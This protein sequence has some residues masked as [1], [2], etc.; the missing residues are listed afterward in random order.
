MNVMQI[1]VLSVFLGMLASCATPVGQFKESDMTWTKF[2]MEM[3]YQSVFRN[4]KEGFR[5]C[6]NNFFADGSLY[7]DVKEGHFDIYLT[8]AFGGKSPWVYGVVNI[9][10]VDENHSTFAVGVV[11]AYDNPMFGKEGGGRE[12]I[13]KWASGT[14]A[15]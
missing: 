10:N 1:I 6:G 14:Y 13:A 12:S 8:D 3:N 11:N 7:T 9:N 4:V 2:E 15:C 5:R